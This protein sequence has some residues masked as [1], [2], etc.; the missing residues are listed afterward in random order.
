MSSE[1]DI[2]Q[3]Q[4]PSVLVPGEEAAKERTRRLSVYEGVVWSLMWGFG[5]S[6]IS[7]FAILLKAGN[8]AMALLGTLPGLVGAFGQIAGA[9]IVERL[10]RRRSISVVCTA[11]QSFCYIPLLII[12]YMFPA[13]AVPVVVSIFILMTTVSNL[14]APGW[15]SMMGDVVP[16]NVR[17]VYFARRN[18]FMIAAMMLA[19]TAAGCALSAFKRYDRVWV[20]FAVLFIIAFLA[21]A[22]S[23]LLLTRHYDP[24]YHASQDTHYSFLDFL[25]QM[26][27]SNFAK[28]TLG[29]A[30]MNGATTIATPFF[31][32]YML[33]DL[34]WTYLQFTVNSVVAM[35][36]QVLV[37]PWWGRISDRH[38]NR[39]VIQATSII[40]PLLPIAW[41]VTTNFYVLLCVQIVS[42][43]TWSG[44]S[45]AVTNFFYDSVTPAKRPR[46]LSY[47]GLVNSAFSLIGGVAVGAFLAGH[48]PS[49]YR[50]GMFHVA[51]VSSLPAVFVVSGVL[52]ILTALFLLPAFKEVRISE[53]ISTRELLRRISCGEPFAG[54]IG[55]IIEFVFAPMHRSDDKA[56]D[57]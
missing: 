52:R 24:P 39:M 32:L 12:P 27:R 47:F 9:N 29:I 34:H 16:D 53:P 43:M 6:Y 31:G 5:E 30:V 36:I 4:A 45:L 33:R 20:G 46:M 48:L 38:G 37:L 28:F 40:I 57:A 41:A 56:G 21:R 14:S 7:P 19:M 44:F 22:V 23:S 54:Q 55:E 35:L 2:S 50:L 11:L 26:P 1:K 25:R 8:T 51:F 15:T 42:G 3:I 49:D 13:V 17:G 18:Q 10:G